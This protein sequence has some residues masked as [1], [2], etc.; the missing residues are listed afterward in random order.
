MVESTLICVSTFV[1]QKKT[2]LDHDQ[3][4][5]DDDDDDDGD[6]DISFTGHISTEHR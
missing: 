4:Q 2:T 5:L 1:F 6:D 3:D